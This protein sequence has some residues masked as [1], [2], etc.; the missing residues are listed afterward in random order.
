MTLV[1]DHMPDAEPIIAI[2]KRVSQESMSN[3]VRDIADNIEKEKEALE[4]L[5]PEWLQRYDEGKIASAAAERVEAASEA[6]T[7]AHASTNSEGSS[8][9]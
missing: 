7:E 8:Q 4:A 3:V 1:S 5:K 2:G 6:A 9:Q